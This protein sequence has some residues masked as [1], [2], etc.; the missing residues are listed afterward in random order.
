MDISPQQAPDSTVRISAT[1]ALVVDDEPLIRWSVSETLTALEMEVEQ[2]ADAAGALEAI[3]R[4]PAPFDV[5]VLDLRLPDVD[6]LSLLRRVCQSLPDAF[7]VLMTAYGS[8]EIAAEALATG[9][10]GVLQ[11]PF[12]LEALSRLLSLRNRTASS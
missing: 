6:D 8:A 7:V 11:K 4:S 9:A 1:R 5:V 2:A 12:E 10:R 3:S